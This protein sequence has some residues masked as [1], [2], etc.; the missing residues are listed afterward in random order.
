MRPLSSKGGGGG[1]V[2]ALVTRPLK[3]TFMRLPLPR[4]YMLEDHR[5]QYRVS[6][7]ELAKG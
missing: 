7:E 2:E 4:F 6:E 3:I 5:Q 1:G